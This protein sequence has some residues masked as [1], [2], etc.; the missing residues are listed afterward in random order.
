LAEL[1]DQLKLG[2]SDR[3]PEGGTP[4][5]KRAERILALKA[6]ATVDDAPVRAATRKATRAEIQMKARIRKR[7]AAPVVVEP[8]PV[9]EKTVR[10]EESKGAPVAV[11]PEPT[12][13]IRQPE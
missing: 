3:A 12:A 7:E 8:V 5:S 13:T 10:N 9:E 6:G 2:L 11:P 1:R 4:L